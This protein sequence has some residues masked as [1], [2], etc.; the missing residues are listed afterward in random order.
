MTLSLLTAIAI[1]MLS[2]LAIPLPPSHGQ[3]A[4]SH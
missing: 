3:P 2:C 4:G 1:G